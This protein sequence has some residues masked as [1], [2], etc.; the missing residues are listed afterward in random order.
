MGDFEGLIRDPEFQSKP[1]NERHAIL[2]KVSPDGYAKAPPSKQT[3]FMI[4]MKSQPWWK[5]SAAPSAPAPAEKPPKPSYF[6]TLKSGIKSDLAE[7]PRFVAEGVTGLANVV[8]KAAHGLTQEVPTYLSARR[9]GKGVADAASAAAQATTPYKPMESPLGPSK[10]GQAI[11]GAVG[12]VVNKLGQVTGQPELVQGVAE[13]AGDVAGLY[14]MK[15]GLRAAGQVKNR[16]ATGKGAPFTTKRADYRAGEI[17]SDVEPVRNALSGVKQVLGKGA[18]EL[19]PV[20]PKHITGGVIGDTL[21]ANEAAV[22]PIVREKYAAVEQDYSLPTAEHTAKVKEVLATPLLDPRVKTI[23]KQTQAEMTKHGNS[24]VV[25]QRADQKLSSAVSEAVMRGD[26]DSARLIGEMRNALKADITKAGEAAEKGDIMAVGKKIIIPSELKAEIAKIDEQI[27]AERIKTPTEHDF[28]TMKDEIR[29]VSSV[30]SEQRVGRSDKSFQQD[31]IKYWGKHYPDRPLP[32]KGGS[33]TSAVLDNL[34]NRRTQLQTTLD[35]A[36]PADNV[37]RTLG[38]ATA[39]AREEQFER[40]YRDEALAVMKPGERATGRRMSNEQIPDQFFNTQTGAKSLV[41]TSMPLKGTVN[42]IT[43]VEMTLPER[44]EM[45]RHSAAKQ[46]MPHV[47]EQLVT[48]TVNPSTGIMNIKQA[49]K[50]I[51]SKKDVLNEFGLLKPAENVVK[52]Q[53]LKSAEY[54]LGEFG[55][56]FG[57]PAMSPRQVRAR[58]R[59]IAPDAE[60]LFGKEA[61][62]ALTEYAGKVRAFKSLYIR[63]MDDM[64]KLV[65]EFRREKNRKTLGMIEK[66]GQAA[67]VATGKGWGYDSIKGLVL[68]ALD[69][70]FGMSD[71]R[72]ADVLIRAEGN[73]EL[74]KGLMRLIKAK[75]TETVS[76]FNK[77]VKPFTKSGVAGIASQSIQPPQEATDASTP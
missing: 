53:V 58:I 29:K 36:H 63:N 68:R 6:E 69:P 47:I 59:L 30:D 42:P 23:I 7:I 35:A 55:E 43:G 31:L 28:Q 41:K 22:K 54:S 8:G 50:F 26:N 52:T 11:S 48:K 9:K 62:G 18:A 77:Y 39:Y 25:L 32:V 3:D 27:A 72:V 65:A 24:M 46:I 57:L 1:W 51:D 34:T 45:G 67:A 4:E 37:A 14:G 13:F 64:E 66:G 44:M 5:G 2:T 17:L 38:E 12:G 49:M 10:T 70:V 60:R 20:Q 16:L 40:F 75:P 73:P 33:A 61:M 21:E 15:P 71:R 74:A 56:V 19:P 76:V